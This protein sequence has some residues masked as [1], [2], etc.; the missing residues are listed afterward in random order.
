MIK[1]L[2]D[3]AGVGVRLISPKIADSGH[4]YGNRVDLLLKIVDEVEDT[5]WVIRDIEI[6]PFQIL[7]LDNASCPSRRKVPVTELESTRDRWILEPRR[8]RGRSRIP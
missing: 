5:S 8:R 3:D 4:G 7:H 2:L 1:T 6:R